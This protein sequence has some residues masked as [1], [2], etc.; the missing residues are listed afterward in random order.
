MA[1]IGIDVS[2]SKLDLLWLRE[3]ERRHIKT[4]V[5]KNHPEAFPS[6]LRWLQATTGEPVDQLHV[7]LEA[8][9]IYHEPLAYWLHDQ[10]V[11]VYVLNP[12]QVRHHAQGGGRRTKT[13][14]KDS[15][16][17]ARYGYERTPPPWEP[18]PPEVRALRR[19]VDRL[20]TLEADIQREENRLEKAQFSGDTQAEESISHMLTALRAERRRLRA[21]LNDHFNH[22]P[23]LKQDRA[24]LETIP[25]VGRILS[26]R[27]PKPVARTVQR[28]KLHYRD[29]H[30][31]AKKYVKWRRSFGVAM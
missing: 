11:R 15:M 27:G 28:L 24:L 13:D 8:T 14:R 16:M 23:Q 17:L 18:E 10:G 22:H 3:P 12:A 25:G 31:T 4:K 2:K 21:A 7:Y 29:G 1:H 5:F 19:L 6:L 26:H 9:G 30:K 20:D